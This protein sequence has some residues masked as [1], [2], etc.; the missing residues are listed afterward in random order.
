LDLGE[1]LLK[2]GDVLLQR[3]TNHSWSNRSAR[4]CRIAVVAIDA[5]PSR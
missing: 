1:A 4:I 5:D 3:G 2:T